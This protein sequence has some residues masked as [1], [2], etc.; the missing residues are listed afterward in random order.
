MRDLHLTATVQRLSV[1]LRRIKQNAAGRATYASTAT[2]CKCEYLNWGVWTAFDDTSST[3]FTTRF[4]S[5]VAGTPTS[6]TDMQGVLSQGGSAT[7]S[8]HVLAMTGYGAAG[9]TLAAGS[10]QSQ[11]NFGARNGSFSVG[12]LD[13]ASY[14]GTLGFGASANPGSITGSAFSSGTGRSMGIGGSF[15]S[16]GGNP[17]SAMG[18]PLAISGPGG[19]VGVGTYAASR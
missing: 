6:A 5:W 1:L 17:V 14:S 16:G 2:A 9:A 11:V 4:G 12:N 15:F 10:F 8:G 13:G 18:G 3:T 19:Y 7:Y